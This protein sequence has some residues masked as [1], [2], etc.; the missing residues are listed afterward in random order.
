[1]GWA[2]FSQTQL[3][4]LLL[5]KKRNIQVVQVPILINIKPYKL[6]TYARYSECLLQAQ[7]QAVSDRSS[8]NTKTENHRFD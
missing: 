1:M 5:T 2:T 6:Y 8:E 3:V 7:M 4:T